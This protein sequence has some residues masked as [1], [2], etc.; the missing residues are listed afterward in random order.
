MEYIC[1]NSRKEKPVSYQLSDLMMRVK[2]ASR[3]DIVHYSVVKSVW[4]S[5]GLGVYSVVITTLDDHQYTIGNRF[6]HDNGSVDDKSNAYALFVRVLHMHLREKSKANFT[7][8]KKF[9]FPD[10]QKFLWVPVAFGIAYGFDYL[11]FSLF[12]WALQG[13]AL[14]AI[15][16][17][18][19]LVSEKN[20]AIEK[21]TSGDIPIEFLPG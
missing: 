5:K 9:Q 12:H 10:W 18:L 6:I 14:T 16:L 7:C 15:G 4:I 3:E 1:K 20:Q 21:S 11:G 2:R 17:L 8:V 19:I 13:I